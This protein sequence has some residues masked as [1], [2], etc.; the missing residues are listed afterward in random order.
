MTTITALEKLAGRNT[1]LGIYSCTFISYGNNETLL[2]FNVGE[3][4]SYAVYYMLSNYT[5][6][7]HMQT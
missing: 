1:W 2:Y 7:D 6:C 4:A 5:I 3:T